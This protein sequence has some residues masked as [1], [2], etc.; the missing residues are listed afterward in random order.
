LA[1]ADDLVLI[2]DSGQKL[3]YNLNLLVSV[4]EKRKFKASLPK[5][6]TMIISRD[7]RKHEIKVRGQVLEQVRGFKYLDTIIS[8]DGKLNNEINS[9]IFAAGRTLHSIKNKCLRKWE[10]TE[11]TKMVVYKTIYFPTLTYGCD[12]WAL[13]T[14]LESRLQTI[15]MHY[16][17]S[18]VGKT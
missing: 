5:T 17:R 16:L 15:E 14:K 9:P 8:K 10:V 13:I 12:L 4:L 18:V 2:A 3:Q 7:E 6:K 11:E 1:Y